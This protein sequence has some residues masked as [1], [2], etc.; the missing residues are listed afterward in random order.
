MVYKVL[1]SSS[2]NSPYTV[3][4]YSINKDS[5]NPTYLLLISRTLS[6]IAYSDIKEI[7]KVRRG[8]ILA[9][10]T[11]VKATNNLVLNTR[12]NTEKLNVHPNVTH[13][14]NR[15]RERYSSI[16][17]WGWILLEF[18][19]VPYKM[20]EVKR[21]NRRVRVNGETKYIPLF[22]WNLWNRFCPSFSLPKP[23]WDLPFCT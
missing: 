6:Q 4:V 2:N 10:M 5:L 16:L 22:A 23:I 21:L 12:L 13:H 18:F 9:E 7:K 20:I 14:Q 1:Y 11:T 15:Y 3:H 8:K 19:D 17:W